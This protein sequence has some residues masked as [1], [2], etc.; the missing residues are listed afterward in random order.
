M[1]RT[2]LFVLS[3]LCAFA[4]NSHPLTP[5]EATISAANHQEISL[6]AR[7]RLDFLFVVDNSGSMC[8]EQANLA[9]NFRHISEFLFAQFG[10]SADF[11]V[12]SVSTDMDGRN[13]LAGHFVTG[14][15]TDEETCGEEG[16]PSADLSYCAELFAT[17]GARPILRSGEDGNIGRLCAN[18]PE[19]SKC[20]A[21]DLEKKFACLVGLGVRGSS[22]ESGLEAMRTALSCDGPNADSFGVCCVD[23]VYDPGC[24][25]PVG[26]EPEFLR[27]DA[28]LVVVVVSDEDD[29]SGRP[30]DGVDH[31][32]TANCL[33]QRDKLVP[34]AEYVD[35]LQSRK[36]NPSKQLI[37][38]TIAGQR[39]YNGDGTPLSYAPGPRDACDASSVGT[40]DASIPL[41]VCCPDGQCRGGARPVCE[42]A[43]GKGYSGTRYLEFSEAF[44]EL[45]VGCPEG[46]EGTEACVHICEPTFSRA[47]DITRDRIREVLTSY[48]L[49]RAPACSVDGRPCADE[50]ERADSANYGMLVRTQC[51]DTEANG[52]PCPRLEPPRLRGTDE[53]S[54]TFDV[55]S[56]ASGARLTLDHL[57]VPGS[58]VT[59]EY[60][61]SAVP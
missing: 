6:P 18:D 47:L 20:V 50:T 8:Q 55:D 3:A 25:P 42:T 38:A 16:T 52:G 51:V 17:A 9:R 21:S 28:V 13:Q 5:L 14:T 19:P 12:A 32:H 57:L 2:T 26:E 31:G 41:D 34:V 49:D 44:G 37:V 59:V 46:E 58:E 45:G 39:G 1:R 53:Y 43:A 33:W 11:R 54:L 10:D 61:V 40:F 29:C 36:A 24:V 30:G 15:G 23:G 22:F 4:C 60:L 35:F 7:T 56:C 27:P 48:C